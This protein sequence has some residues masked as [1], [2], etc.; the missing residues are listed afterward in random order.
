VANDIELDFPERDIAT[1]IV[2]VKHLVGRG[3][4]PPPPALELLLLEN[5]YEAWRLYARQMLNAK[6]Q[7][8]QSG[9]RFEL[10]EWKGPNPFNI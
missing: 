1:A 8:R 7:A 4:L 6:G 3:L 10:G 2:E 9:M 5:D